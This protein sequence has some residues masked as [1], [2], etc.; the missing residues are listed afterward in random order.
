MAWQLLR[1]QSERVRKLLSKGDYM[2]KVRKSVLFFLAL[3]VSLAMPPSASD[4]FQW[5]KPTIK[6]ESISVSGGALKQKIYQFKNGDVFRMY[7]LE[8]Q[9]DSSPYVLSVPFAGEGSTF[10]HVLSTDNN[11]Q[12]TRVWNLLSLAETNELPLVPGFIESPSRYFWV[13]S[14]IVYNPLGRTTIEEKKELALPIAVKKEWYRMHLEVQL[15]VKA[16]MVSEWWIM[17]SS[18]PLV[19]WDS[20]PTANL[21]LGVDLSDKA[22]W[23]YDGYYYTSPSTYVPYTV[24]AFWRNPENYVVRSFLANPTSKAAQNMAYVMLDTAVRNQE[25]EGHWKTYPQS[26]WLA[27][28]YGIPDGFYDTRFNTGMAELLLDGCKKY[29]ESEFCESA[30]RYALYLRNHASQYHYVIPGPT[31]GWLVADYAH[32]TPHKPTH[33]SLNH[34]LAEINFLW[35]MYM[36]FQDPADQALATVMLQGVT[37][38]GERWITQNGDLHYAWFPDDTFGRPD[39]PYLTYNDLRETQRLYRSLYGTEQPVI[40]Q[41]MKSKEMWMA[42]NKVVNP[43]Q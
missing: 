19:P 40:A 27:D 17:E 7:R 18:S 26:Q 16:G 34:Q 9:I 31:D 32:P 14:P 38:L 3:L 29:N 28:D 20:E 41:L 33:V 43:F 25:A 15:P 42:A 37:N 10:R 36:Q 35:K 30:K 5:E 4:A 39:Y 22:K 1:K 8:G 11:G 21:W 13:A 2:T 23:L 6:E 12:I 24:N